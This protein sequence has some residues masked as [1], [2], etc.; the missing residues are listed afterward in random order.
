MGEH[1]EPCA[2]EAEAEESITYWL[3]WLT[4]NEKKNAITWVTR[5]RVLAVDEDGT[6]TAS[7]S[8]QAEALKG[9][10]K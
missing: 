10:T 5:Y 6:I 4:T 8:E 1:G 7:N 2:T 3:L 9:C